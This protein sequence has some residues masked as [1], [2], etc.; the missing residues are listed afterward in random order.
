[1]LTVKLGIIF[2]FR[3]QKRQS[4]KKLSIEILKKFLIALVQLAVLN[5]MMRALLTHVH[6]AN[7]E[8]ND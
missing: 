4:T 6:T 3:A 5:V 7:H 8:I 1:M 2:S